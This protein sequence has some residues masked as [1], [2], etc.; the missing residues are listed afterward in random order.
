MSEK[1]PPELEERALAV[2]LE[3]LARG[4]S[5]RRTHMLQEGLVLAAVLVIFGASGISDGRLIAIVVVAASLCIIWAI[6]SVSASLH[7]Q[8][9]PLVMVI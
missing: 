4:R 5:V 9:D 8:L 2:D 6:M 3:S 7:R 1:L